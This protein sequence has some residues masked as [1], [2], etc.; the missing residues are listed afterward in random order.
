MD[1]LVGNIAPQGYIA[2]MFLVPMIGRGNARKLRAQFFMGLRQQLES[3]H[4]LKGSQMD[5][6][7]YL[8]LHAKDKA[9][10]AERHVLR[11][12]FQGQGIGP[13]LFYIHFLYFYTKHS[14]H[15]LVRLAGNFLLA[16]AVA[17]G[18]LP[19]D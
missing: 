10:V 14:P 8:P 6:H 15:I 12:S 11:Y 9:V 13:D 7:E 2:P 18:Q 3:Y 5:T 16:H 4:R 1:A 19:Q 17:L